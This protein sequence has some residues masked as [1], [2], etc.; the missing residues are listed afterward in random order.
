V[1]ARQGSTQI[2]LSH[3]ENGSGAS[4]EPFSF[5]MSNLCSDVHVL[6]AGL[7]QAPLAL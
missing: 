4:P 7:A 3:L 5:E 1:N 2:K 6:A